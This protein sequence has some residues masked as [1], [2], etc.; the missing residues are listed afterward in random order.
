MC[1]INA[2]DNIIQI[3]YIKLR[4]TYNH[5]QLYLNGTLT[6]FYQNSIDKHSVVTNTIKYNNKYDT[7]IYDYTIKDK[8]DITKYNLKLFPIKKYSSKL[9]DIFGQKSFTREEFIYT[10]DDFINSVDYKVFGL[11]NNNELLEYINNTYLDISTDSI[12][13]H[14]TIYNYDEIYDVYWKNGKC[15]SDYIKRIV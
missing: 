14:N 8:T 3:I 11:Y 13:Y 1:S 15:F 2:I 7:Y 10:I 9:F 4:L 5:I 6:V 12:V